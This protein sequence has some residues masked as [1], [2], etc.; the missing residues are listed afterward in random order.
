MHYALIEMAM[1]SEV[2]G[3]LVRIVEDQ[4]KPLALDHDPEI[5]STQPLEPNSE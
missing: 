4:R 3:K 1:G 5:P 2:N